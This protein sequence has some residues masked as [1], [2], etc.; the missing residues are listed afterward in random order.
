M[1]G[2]ELTRPVATLLGV[3]VSRRGI[4]PEE[5]GR[6]QDASG[7]LHSRLVHATECADLAGFINNTG[8]WSVERDRRSERACGSHRLARLRT[9]H[10]SANPEG[11]CTVLVAAPS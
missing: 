10:R 4:H 8:M 5:F 3:V 1:R 2:V 7:E 6:R 9:F 11:I